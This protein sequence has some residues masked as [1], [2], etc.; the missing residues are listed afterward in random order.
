MTATRSKAI[1]RPKTHPA[2]FSYNH[3]QRAKPSAT[4]AGI[5]GLAN[6]PRVHHLPAPLT[7]HPH[8]RVRALSTP[9]T[10]NAFRQEE[11]G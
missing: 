3:A 10:P 8:P 4:L 9:C 2:P 5:P 11:K 1:K 7:A 6:S